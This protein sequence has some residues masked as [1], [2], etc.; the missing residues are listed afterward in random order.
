M[1]ILMT[2]VVAEIAV[3]R[4]PHQPKNFQD[5]SK[6]LCSH[7]QCTTMCVGCFGDPS[8]LYMPANVMQQEV[9]TLRHFIYSM[10][11]AYFG[12]TGFGLGSLIFGPHMN[13][14]VHFSLSFCPSNRQYYILLLFSPLGPAVR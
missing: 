5:F 8:L 7:V 6:L 10:P 4:I 1:T 3:A 11:N 14:H 2:H 12:R 13:F 9:G